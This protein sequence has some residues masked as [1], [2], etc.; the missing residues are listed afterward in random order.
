MEAIIACAIIG[1]IGFPVAVFIWGL[2]CTGK[3]S[4]PS[5]TPMEPM[6]MHKDHYEAQ[7]GISYDNTPK[8]T[9]PK[10]PDIFDQAIA[11]KIVDSIWG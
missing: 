11:Y 2:C 5:V 9:I 1:C 10:H 4:G 8:T 7:P 6:E 3:S